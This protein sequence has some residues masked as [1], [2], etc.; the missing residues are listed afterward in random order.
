M[1]SGMSKTEIHPCRICGEVPTVLE[2]THDGV[3]KYSLA[4]RHSKSENQCKTPIFIDDR[5]TRETAIADW[6]KENPL[7]KR[8]IARFSEDER[9]YFERRYDVLR[10]R[11]EDIKTN[12]ERALL[13][14]KT[15]TYIWERLNKLAAMSYDE[16]MSEIEA[17]YVIF[18]YGRINPQ[19]CQIQ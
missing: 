10:S 11:I 5:L 18:D 3:T 2:F 9:A 16:L 15:D 17:D 4:C 19:E 14:P 13:T 1:V 12:P 8:H 7:I 6:N